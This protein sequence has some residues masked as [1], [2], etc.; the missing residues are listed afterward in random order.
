MTKILMLAFSLLISGAW[1]QAQD[2][3]PLRATPVIIRRSAQ[4]FLKDAYRFQ[5]AFSRLPTIQE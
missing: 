5:L 4:A 3:A 1:I 2:A